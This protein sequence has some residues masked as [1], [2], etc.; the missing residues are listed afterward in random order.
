VT[1]KDGTTALGTSTLAAGTA[2]LSVSSL[3]TG[4]HSITAVY[5][6]SA[7]YLTSTSVAL[8]HVV[9]QNATT[10]A[11]VSSLN[12]ATAGTAVTF[13]ATVNAAFG[14]PT[15]TVTFKDGATTI[16]TG[17]VSSAKIATLTTKTLT[18]ATHAITAVYSGDVNDLTST[19][20]ALSQ[21]VH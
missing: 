8:A 12:P 14:L 15:G 11:L 16:G 1:F 6:G 17:T 19:S 18:V 10:T 21:V 7:G 2:T 13:T 3:T 20:A 5:N 4:S 9:S